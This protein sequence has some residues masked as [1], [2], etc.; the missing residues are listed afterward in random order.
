MKLPYVVTDVFTD[1]RFGGNQLAVVLDA[2]KLTQAQ[3]QAVARAFNF[4]ETTFV[5]PPEDPAN[6]RRVR[7][8][9]PGREIP[10]AGHPNVG[11]ACVLAERGELGGGR[12]PWTMVFEEE[13]GRVTLE[14][15]Q[16]SEDVLRAE[17]TAPQAPVI[18]AELDP[19]PVAAA[20]GLAPTSIVTRRHAP[21]L[22]SAG[23]TFVCVEIDDREALARARPDADALG[24]LPGHDA[25]HGSI[26]VYTRDAGV[27]GADLRARMFAPG[28]GVPEDPA[29]GSAAAALSGLLGGIAETSTGEVPLVIAQGFE[30]GRP[31]RIETTAVKANGEVTAVRVAGPAVTFAEG[32]LRI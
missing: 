1:R 4:S 9:T 13:A 27:P 19:E 18:G 2:A 30:M 20:V 6:T 17:F 24:R 11:T 15:R 3:M 10:F 23:M 16:Q 31:S 22:A 14:V 8:F 28:L 5:L 29:T 32:T 12:G 21:R 26:L 25:H 7:I